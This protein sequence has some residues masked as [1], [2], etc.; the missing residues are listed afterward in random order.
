MKTEEL[1]RY[2]VEYK[3]MRQ[4]LGTYLLVFE[5]PKQVDSGCIPNEGAIIA[6]R[7]DVGFGSSSA[8]AKPHKPLFM[9]A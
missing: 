6:R 3:A 8:A 7:G 9:V 5:F 1:I 4:A 2:E